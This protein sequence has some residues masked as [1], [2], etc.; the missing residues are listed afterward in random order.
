MATNTNTNT[1]VPTTIYSRPMAI[2]DYSNVPHEKADIFNQCIPVFSGISAC[3]GI[4]PENLSG[5]LEAKVFGVT[6]AHI[7]IKIGEPVPLKFGVSGIGTATF[8]ISIFL[9]DKGK[10]TLR[11]QYN[12][13]GPLGFQIADNS[14]DLSLPF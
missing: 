5:T 1:L 3:V 11:I 6:V 14:V 7:Q 12:I 2:H 8:V 10:H 4:D 13:T 9:N